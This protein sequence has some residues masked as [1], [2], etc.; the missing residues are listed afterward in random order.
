MPHS[1]IRRCFQSHF[2]QQTP[3]C[4]NHKKT[5]RKDGTSFPQVKTSVTDTSRN[6]VAKCQNR[7]KN[8]HLFQIIL[9]VTAVANKVRQ[10]R[11][12]W[13]LWRPDRS[14]PKTLSA[15]SLKVIHGV[16][17]GKSRSKT[18]GLR[19]LQSSRPVL[20]G[21]WWWA[22]TGGIPATSCPPVKRKPGARKSTST[23]LQDP[24]ALHLIP[25]LRP[26]RLNLKAEPHCPPVPT[27]LRP[28]VFTLG[29][30]N[31]SAGIDVMEWE[32]V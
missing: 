2:T 25:S 22:V 14:Q 11:R 15:A 28:L 5:K 27:S 13:D 31:P 21:A 30:W 17:C 9:C 8:R 23:P 26:W 16:S 10:P 24:L 4:L 1:V 19:P 32:V 18:E 29:H 12:S 3:E 7:G 20:G 6:P